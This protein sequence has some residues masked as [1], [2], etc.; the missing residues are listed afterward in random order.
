MFDKACSFVVDP[1]NSAQ[2]L[3]L[4]QNKVKEEVIQAIKDGF[5]TFIVGVE[6]EWDTF[7]AELVIE[8]K[9]NHAD[10]FLEAAVRSKLAYKLSLMSDAL[11]KG[12]DGFRLQQGQYNENSTMN[13][14][15]YMMNLSDRVI[16]LFSG[17]EKGRSA[18]AMKHAHCTGKSIREIR[19]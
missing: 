4:V 19:L 2:N 8:Q 11:I 12:Y 6:S 3:S 15:R 1:N 7:F 18:F 5:T 10:L 17:R 14:D 9:Q 16:I 13:S